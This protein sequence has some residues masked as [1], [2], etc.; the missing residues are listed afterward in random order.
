RLVL[1]AARGRPRGGRPRVPR[2]AV[3]H[4]ALVRAAARGGDGMTWAAW[5]LQRTETLIAAAILALLVVILVPTGIEMA[6]AFH[7]DGLSACLGQVTSGSCDEAV[8]SFT[9]RFH[10]VGGLVDWFTLVPGLLGVL[11]AAPFV[12]DLEHGTYRL[13]WT[14][15]ITRRRWL[16]GKLGL[17]V[18]CALA[19]AFSLI[20]LVTWWRAPLVR[21]D[22]RMDNG[23]FD[24]EGIGVFGSEG[25]V[26]LGYTLFG[27]GL[28]AAVGAVWRRAV[29]A[30]IVGFV[31]Y[32][33]SRIFVDVWLRQRLLSPLK[34][35]WK[36]DAP[37]PS[38][39]RHAWV[40]QEGPSD[41]FGHFVQPKVGACV[42]AAKGG[43]RLLDPGCL[44]H[45]AGFSMHAVYHPASRFWALQGIETAIFGAV[46][47]GLI[48]FAAWW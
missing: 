35:T 42:R 19:A 6:N 17:A 36:F 25:I 34:A 24:S 40:L 16:A 23:V 13:A 26:V 7:H 15:S 30:L 20:L 48:G 43:A 41:R 2:P 4:D 32:L 27:L 10:R 11:L 21:I 5:R 31:G 14:Q 28:G 18:A 39:L 12:L 9:D 29:P 46:A 8:P 3:D 45:K 1:A 37:S 47:V 22:G 33:V 38:G 44:S